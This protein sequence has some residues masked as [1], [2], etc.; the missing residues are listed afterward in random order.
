MDKAF[1][2]RFFKLFMDILNTRA[3]ENPPERGRYYAFGL[4][5]YASEFF[6]PLKSF[7]DKEA[8]TKPYPEG[9][10]TEFL[11][12]ILNNKYTKG[13]ITINE[14]IFGYLQ[15]TGRFGE[16]EKGKIVVYERPDRQWTYLQL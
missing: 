9:A 8:D 6:E 5:S 13:F 11:E 14:K 10:T 12:K 2:D 15:D 1:Q 7:L 3:W 16:N 4:D